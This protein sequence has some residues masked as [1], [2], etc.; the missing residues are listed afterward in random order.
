MDDERTL[1]EARAIL[2][3]QLLVLDGLSTEPAN[4]SSHVLL[5]QQDLAREAARERWVDELIEG[6]P[7][8]IDS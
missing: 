4:S 8:S 7:F 6:L 1:V 5:H 3:Q 2:D